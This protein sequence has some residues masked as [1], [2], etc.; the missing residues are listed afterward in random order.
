MQFSTAEKALFLKIVYYGPGLSGKTT[1]LETLHRLTDP[2]GKQAL[3]SLKTEGDRTL[4]FDLMPFDLGRL[5]GMDVRLKV[6]TVPGQVQYDI[7]RRQVLSGADAIVFVADSQASQ[8]EANLQ[9]IKYL[10]SNLRMNGLDP[11]TIPLVFQW[12]KRDMPGL[13][14]AV[15]LNREINFRPQ[16]CIGIEAVATVGTG[17]LETFQE[18]VLRTIEAV[19]A[20]G[21]LQGVSAPVAGIRQKVGALF[22]DICSRAKTSSNS[23]ARPV[24]HVNAPL[25][26]SRT[27]AARDKTGKDVLEL[28][29]LLFEAVQASLDMSEQLT[30]SV[31]GEESQARLKRERTALLRLVQVA[32]LSPDTAG[33]LRMALAAALSGLD[34]KQGAALT[35]KG[36]GQPLN[37]IAVSGRERDPL[38]EIVTP[39]IGSVATTLLERGQP[40]NCTDIRGELLFGADYP[41]VEGL[42]GVLAMPVR[43][44]RDAN[45]LLL[46]YVARNARDLDNEDIE[47]VGLCA[48][49]AGLALRL[50]AAPA[51]V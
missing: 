6:Y 10:K 14:S 17:V 26:A 13:M 50:V 40:L 22:A 35:W 19:A 8:L 45:A 25:N 41:A 28:D 1:N 32:S 12:N 49:I 44:K 20:K 38:N 7:T 29:D 9:M 47:W 3:V 43:S 48:A 30:R 39:S 2:D 5:Y 34:F 36:T 18:I 51:A 11:N 33:I 21:A 4:F 27:H 23:S 15:D 46:I 37:E 31:S 24:A 16:D 42:R